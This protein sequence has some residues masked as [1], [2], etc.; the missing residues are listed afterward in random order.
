MAAAAKTGAPDIKA[1]HQMCAQAP[2]WETVAG[3]A[4]EGERKMAPARPQ[5]W[6]SISVGPSCFKLDACSSG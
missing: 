6:E 5:T 2:F 1:G 4:A 3:S